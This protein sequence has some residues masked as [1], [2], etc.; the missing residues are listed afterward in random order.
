MLRDDLHLPGCPVDREQVRLICDYRAAEI[1]WK[2]APTLSADEHDRYRRTT[3]SRT[4]APSCLT[5]STWSP[6]SP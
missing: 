5:S 1:G 6:C 4:T 3:V 2:D